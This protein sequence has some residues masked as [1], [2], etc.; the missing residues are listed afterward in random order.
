MA[1]RT[2]LVNGTDVELGSTSGVL[3]VISYP[4]SC[5]MTEVD[6]ATDADVVVTAAPCYLMGLYVNVVFSAH[7]VN[8]IDNVTTMLVLPASMAAGTKIDCHSAS[9]ATNLSVNSDNAATGKLLV[10]WRAA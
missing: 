1:E 7:A 4:I 3:K 5:T 6:L 8:I 2:V 9:F 10:F